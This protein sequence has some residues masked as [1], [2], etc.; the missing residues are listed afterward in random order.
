MSLPMPRR[1]DGLGLC[2]PRLR[3]ARAS[4]SWAMG[5]FLP[6]SCFGGRPVL[7]PCLVAPRALPL[8]EGHSFS[9]NILCSSTE[10]DRHP[11]PSCERPR[12]TPAMYWHDSLVAAR[13]HPSVLSANNQL[14][15]ALTGHSGESLIQADAAQLGV[16]SSGSY[17]SQTDLWAIDEQVSWG[18]ILPRCG[19]SGAR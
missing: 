10:H 18:E 4:V 7:Y 1:P 5:W 15:S 14:L 17:T 6:G 12:L 16:S 2:F 3:D 8:H 11:P 9:G 13:S 19:R